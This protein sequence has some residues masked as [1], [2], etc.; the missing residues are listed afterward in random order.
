MNAWTHWFLV[1]SGV[2]WCWP[3]AVLWSSFIGKGPCELTPAACGGRHPSPWQKG[4]IQPGCTYRSFFPL[5]LPCML[6]CPFSP[7]LSPHQMSSSWTKLLTSEY[8]QAMEGE[9]WSPFFPADL[10]TASFFSP[11]SLSSTNRQGQ[12][13]EEG[14]KINPTSLEVW[15]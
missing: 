6:A 8:L 9:K 4:G 15:V 10:K 13:P 11:P 3:N 12:V 14:E 1:A 2:G 5:F 7:S